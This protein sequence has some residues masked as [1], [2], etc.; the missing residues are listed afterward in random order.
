MNV[1]DAADDDDAAALLI[2]IAGD[3]DGD[4]GAA[5]A[6]QITVSVNVSVNVNVNVCER[7]RERDGDCAADSA[8]LYFLFFPA[9]QIIYKQNKTKKQHTEKYVVLGWRKN[10]T[11]SHERKKQ[12]K[13][14][15]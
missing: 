7:E 5:A 15:L 13:K 2:V 3:G 14:T 6:I 12:H 1:F 11:P 10:N 4:D 8:S 9:P